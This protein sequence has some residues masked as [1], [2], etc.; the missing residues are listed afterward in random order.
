MSNRSDVAVVGGGI[1]GL[2]TAR[3]LLDADPAL[4][5]TVLEA[6]PRVGLHQS[7]H[8]SGVLHAGVY[9]QPG[10]AK[11]EL[12]RRGKAEMERFCEE[13]GI[14]VVRNGKLI[15]ALDEGEL[16]R[17]DALVERATANGVP[18]LRV[19]GPGELREIEPH[20]AGIRALHSPSTGVVDFGAVC[21]ALADELPDVRVGHRV[22]AMVESGDG[23]RLETA[24]GPVEA[25]MAVVCGGV[26]A[27]TLAASAGLDTGLRVVPF[28][29]SW[30]EL[31]PEGGDLVRGNI[32][33]V[34]DPTL[35]FLGVHFTRRFDGR[36]WAGPNAVLSLAH[37]RL[38]ARALG[39]PGL[40][41]LAWTH[42][43]TAVREL[44]EDRVR[45]A[46]LRQ[47]RRYVP[48]VGAEHLRPA[49]PFGIRAQ[50]LGRDGR[51][52]DDFVIE[53]GRRVVHVLNAPSPA[54]TSSLAIGERVAGEVRARW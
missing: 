49:R 16:A 51:L 32:Y 37:P 20:A 31:T 43:A 38:L 41:R 47:M 6:E 33:P 11:A 10:S 28:R 35:P 2:A 4:R 18:D 45:R 15:V 50:A 9:Y 24:G 5:V 3:K 39:H 34:P 21:R 40:Y 19:L 13:H 23:V 26:R 54:A 14:P 30:L 25:R 48:E 27:E 36:V 7:S 29:G 42:R 53:G 12:C 44:Y 46:Y 52:V 17:F 22:T 8:N 1:V